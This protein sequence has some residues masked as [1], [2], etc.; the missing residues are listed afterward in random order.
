MSEV[1]Q[2]IGSVMNFVECADGDSILVS[3]Y[4]NCTNGGLHFMFSLK[5]ALKS[6]QTVSSDPFAALKFS[7]RAF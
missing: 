2:F 3:C 1:Q 7:L 5:T 4:L 6:V